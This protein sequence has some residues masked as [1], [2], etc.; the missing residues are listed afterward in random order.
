MNSTVPPARREPLV[1]LVLA[2]L[3]LA[4]SGVGPKDRFTWLLEV[5]RS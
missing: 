5:A 1:L 4:V 3:A 2:G